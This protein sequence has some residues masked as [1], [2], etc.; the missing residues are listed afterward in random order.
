MAWSVARLHPRR[1][2]TMNL[3]GV[4]RAGLA[5]PGLSSGDVSCWSAARR[6][7]SGGAPFSSTAAT[8]AALAAS[9][10]LAAAQ[11]LGWELS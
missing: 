8:A 4:S 1:T 2:Y 3:V 6:P 10:Q 11:G 9:A 5:D 7:P